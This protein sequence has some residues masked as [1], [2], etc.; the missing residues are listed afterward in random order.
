MEPKRAERQPKCAVQ[1][2]TGVTL[3]NE[4]GNGAQQMQAGAQ[5][6]EVTPPVQHFF[7]AFQKFAVFIE[8]ARNFTFFSTFSTFEIALQNYRRSF[9][10]ILTLREWNPNEQSY[11]QNAQYSRVLE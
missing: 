1:W 10:G 9:K 3:Y 6:A 7:R 11:S 5:L 4:E 2:S 8:I